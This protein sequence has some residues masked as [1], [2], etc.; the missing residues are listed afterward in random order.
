MASLSHARTRK[1]NCMSSPQG[2]SAVSVSQPSGY[3]LPDGNYYQPPA[4]RPLPPEGRPPW[5]LPASWRDAAAVLVYVACMFLGLPVLLLMVVMAAQGQEFSLKDGN[6]QAMAQTVT[7]TVLLVSLLLILRPDF[8]RALGPFRTHPAKAW[9]L[10]PVAFIANLVILAGAGAIIDLISGGVSNSANQEGLQEMAKSASFPLMAI[11]TVVC[12]PIAEE[13]FFRNLLIGKLSARVNQ[14]VC[15]V[16][17]SLV[18]ALIHAVAGWPENP[19]TL[20]PYFVM[21]LT[22]GTIYILSGK[23]FL[24]SSVIHALHNLMALSFLYLIPSVPV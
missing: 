6:T 21:G 10:I 8:K 19:L 22:F 4:A 11:A 9:G 12:A 23:S 7:Y 16:L 2:P 1:M 17:S 5:T 3:F 18:F 15:L 14:W 13:Y 24:Y 20:V